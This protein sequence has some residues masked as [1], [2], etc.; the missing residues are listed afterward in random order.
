MICK[1]ANEIIEFK[2]LDH[3]ILLNSLEK[4]VVSNM[5]PN[6]QIA[7]NCVDDVIPI[8]KLLNKTKFYDIYEVN[9]QIIQMQK[10]EQTGKYYAR[11][12]YDIQNTI[13]EIC[14]DDIN[15]M[16]NDEYLLTQ[17][18]FPWFIMKKHKA[19]WMHG[20]SIL[21]NSK[22]ILFSAPSGVGKSTHTR[23]WKQYVPNIEHINDDKNIII[24]QNNQLTLYGN[25]WS[26][27]HQID[28]N[29]SAP[30]VAIVFLYQSKE[31][32]IVK[33]SKKEAFLKIFKQVIQPFDKSVIDDWNDVTDELLKVPIYELGCNISVDA[34]NLI[35]KT[36][37]EEVYEN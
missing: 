24:F 2:L 25:P 23:L 7:V 6:F 9:N 4:Y 5:K 26:G 21:F 33:L 11:I 3:S 19:I 22:A 29:I 31:N 17:Y 12:L 1:I 34:V 37:E 13:I 10:N 18:V 32:K 14:Q 35:K 16:A 8:G 36:L 30:L 28:S 20:S 15:K 27:K